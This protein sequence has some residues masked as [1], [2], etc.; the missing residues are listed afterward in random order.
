MKDQNLCPCK[1]GKP[2]SKCCEPYI[3]GKENAPTAEALMRSR[4]TAFVKKEVDYIIKTRHPSAGPNELELDII[5]AW[6]SLQIVRTEDG[7]ENDTHGIVEFKANAIVDH[8]IAVLHEVSE[9]EKND[10]QWFY[11]DG[12]INESF[13]PISQKIGRNVPCPCGSGKKFKKC[14]GK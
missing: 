4:Y 12:Q 8:K 3:T 2:Y 6:I 9:F 5:P 13:R 11:V 1:S 14:C 7:Q 10:G